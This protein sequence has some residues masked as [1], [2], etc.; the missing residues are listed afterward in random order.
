MKLAALCKQFGFEKA[1]VWSA[2]RLFQRCI[3]CDIR[4][5]M[6][7]DA[8]T[9]SKVFPSFHRDIDFRFLTTDEVRCFAQDDPTLNGPMASRI[10]SGFDHCF[11]AVF[12]GHRLASY[13]WLAKHSIEA[14][15]N[16]GPDLGIPISFSSTFCFRHK[17]VT[18][19]EFRGHGI[20][21]SL[22]YHAYH[23]MFREFGV[24]N[25]L[26]TAEWVDWDALRRSY[27]SGYQFAGLTVSLHACG[28]NWTRVPDLRYRH[29]AFGKCASVVHRDRIVSAVGQL[30]NRMTAAVS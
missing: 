5:V 4:H 2:Y 22:L 18:Q 1:A 23:A 7:Q 3:R 20:D 30:S 10:E 27:A 6:L 17:T 12:R 26:S 9:M 28:Q 24:R 21:R 25:I 8:K 15:H 29:I 14:T 19:P 13:C 16:G 11:A